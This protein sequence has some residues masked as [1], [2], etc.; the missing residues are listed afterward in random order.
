MSSGL[1]SKLLKKETRKQILQAQWFSS[2][3]EV[4]PRNLYFKHHNFVQ[5][6]LESLLQMLAASMH[7]RS[8]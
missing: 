7:E 6:S 5:L 8:L 2:G 4:R 3:T 1:P